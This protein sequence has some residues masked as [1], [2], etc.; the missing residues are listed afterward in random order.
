MRI[1]LTGISSN[2]GFW[3]A[4]A[5][6]DNGHEVTGTLTRSLENY[7]SPLRSL[8]FEQLLKCVS[9]V[10]NI[11]FGDE[12]FIDLIKSG[13]WGAVIH[14]GALATSAGHKSTDFDWRVAVE[15]NT[16]NVEDVMVAMADS[17]I[18]HFVTTGSF[19][20]ACVGAGSDRGVS[21]D[22]YG[23]SKHIT[24]EVLRYAARLHDIH[25]GKVSIPMP[26]GV[27]EE[28][29][30]ATYLAKTWFKGDTPSVRTPKYVRDYIPFDL[31]G[32]V[33]ADFVD[34]FCAGNTDQK[35]E[36]SFYVATNLG[37]AKM[38]SEKLEPLF[39]IDCPVESEDQTEF[40]EPIIRLNTDHVDAK[41]YNWDEEKFWHD[42][43]EFYQSFYNND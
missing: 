31:M 20:E 30:F 3:I 11:K 9:P 42:L 23:F 19:Y 25:I 4:K 32:M 28:P 26:F 18:R 37:F 21:F 43:A 27:M 15:N 40:K 10:E 17:G 2:T 24:W 22:A 16:H 39:G 13:E 5:L 33:Y 14:H 36:P 12:K 7:N 29:K 35:V 1:L 6:A 38:L 41:K 8:R 34:N